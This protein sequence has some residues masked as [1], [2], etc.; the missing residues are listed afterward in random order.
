VVATKSLVASTLVALV[1]ATPGLA[2]DPTV[3]INDADQTL[4]ARSL[5]RSSDFGIGWRG[6]PTTPTKLTG[7][8][9]PGFNPKVSDLV[10]TGH[11]NASFKNPRAG[12][13][14]SLDTQVLESAEAVRTDFARTVQP[15]LADCLEYQ[16]KQGPSNFASVTVDPLDFPRIGSATAAYRATILVRTD[17]R[18]ARVLSDFVFFGHG[19]MEYSLN[20]VAPA[21][22]RP[23]LVPFE[24]DMARILVKRGARPE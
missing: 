1:L 16:F 11:A 19:R 10:V 15:P 8:S 22:Y 14:I 21:R 6:G 3:R 7:P 20:V 17:G 9:C 18:T 2:D 24:A 5:L 13:Q 23:Q 12:V 4:A